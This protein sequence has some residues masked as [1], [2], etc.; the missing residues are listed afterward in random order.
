MLN[1]DIPGMQAHSEELGVGELFDVFACMLTARS[2]ARVKSG[3]QKSV[4]GEQEVSKI[5]R[6]DGLNIDTIGGSRE[7]CH[8]FSFLDG[9]YYEEDR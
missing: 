6:F 5:I 7:T 3:I 2:W 1:A 8:H 9:R 4:V